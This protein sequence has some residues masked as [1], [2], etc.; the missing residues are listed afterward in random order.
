M[1]R[2]RP[3]YLA[4]FRQQ[5]VELARSGRSRQELAREFNVSA[6]SVTNWI[7]QADADKG[8]PE[9]TRHVLT[10]AEREELAQL[11]RENRRL[12]QE[13]DI[14][15]EATTWFATRGRVSTAES[16]EVVAANQASSPTR[17]LCPAPG[18]SS[19]GFHGLQGREPSSR[20]KA[21]ER[22]LERIRAAH[23]ESDE[24]YGMPRIRAELAEQ[25]VVAS[26]KRIARLMRREDL[27]GVCRRRGFVT[28]TSRNRRARSAPD[29]VER[30]FSASGP[31][32]L[33]VAD[34]TY[35]PSWSGFPCLAV[36][37]DLWSRRVVGWA[38][39]DTM[40]TG[41][42]LGALGMAVEQRRPESVIHHS[43]Q[44]AR[45]TSVAFGSRCRQMGVCP[46]VLPLCW[47]RRSV[48]FSSA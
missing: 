28:T 14:L 18:V 2:T 26:R 6:Q 47:T 24:T 13:R 37:L 23:A 15:A 25:G 44:D 38:M 1:P 10:S 21:N 9:A 3:P 19:S 4:E 48:R 46:G 17:T 12:K 35:V 16:H 36:V 32:Q 7:R 22:L 29:P 30:N 5:P 34:M 27:R 45:Y 39:G 20:A 31:D 42:V 40:E 33:W 41:L 43:D 11:R 8:K